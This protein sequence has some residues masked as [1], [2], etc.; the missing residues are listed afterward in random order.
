MRSSLPYTRP[1][2][3]LSTHQPIISG[4]NPSIV[5]DL[6]FFLVIPQP[7]M[8]MASAESDVSLYS[9]SKFSYTKAL[10]KYPESHQVI[11]TSLLAEMGL[12]TNGDDMADKADIGG[13]GGGATGG[14]KKKKQTVVGDDD[15]NAAALKATVRDALKKRLAAALYS[16]MDAAREG[17][18]DRVKAMLMRGLD[19]NAADYDK[20]STLHLSC[21]EGNSKVVE[22]LIAE[23][24]NVHALDRYGY[25]ALHYAVVNNHALI[26]DLLSRNGAELNY[27]KP[28][29]ALCAAAGHGN[30]DRIKVLVKY[31][32]GVNSADFDGRT[33]LH[34]ASSQGNLRVV[35]LLL[36]MEADVNKQDRWGHTPL[37]EAVGK[38]HDLV[39]AALFARGGE[40]NMS[41][42]K[43]NFM[44]GE[45]ID[46]KGR[47]LDDHKH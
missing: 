32:V 26:A 20:R 45:K 25:N 3:N 23:G 36:S 15:D 21:A 24:A 16:M 37:D 18:A 6:S 10:E 19:I 5:G 33:A 8:I 14:N 4:N 40:L 34:L 38:K 31:G 17:D 13:E 27:K 47:E 42:A 2:P 29:D 44:K 7:H 22:L 35:E 1:P 12:D 46:K 39:A 11:V 28:A 43:G 41:T 9:L 30:M